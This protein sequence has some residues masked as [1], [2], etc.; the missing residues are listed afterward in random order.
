VPDGGFSTASGRDLHR[1]D[2]DPCLSTPEKFAG[3]CLGDLRLGG[4]P[5]LHNQDAHV[6]PADL[7]RCAA[8]RAA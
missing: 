2:F 3:F 4:Q 5:L 1:Y 6:A 8:Q 7:Q